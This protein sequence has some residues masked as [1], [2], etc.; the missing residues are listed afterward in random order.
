[1]RSLASGKG[2][3]ETAQ[4]LCLS[5]STVATYRSRILSKLGLRNTGG[6]V[7]YAVTHRLID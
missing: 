7:R 1:M 6:A 4:E 3:T 5:T 2:L